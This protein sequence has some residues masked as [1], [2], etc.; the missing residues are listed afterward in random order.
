MIHEIL[1]VGPLQCNCSILGDETSREAIVVD[2]GDDI[3]R[4]LA[5]LARHSLT[6]KQ[7]S[8]AT[9]CNKDVV[10]NVIDGFA[11]EGQV[12]PTKIKK[13]SGKGEREYA[14]WK[15]KPAASPVRSK[16][17]MV[18]RASSMVSTPRSIVMPS[19]PASRTRSNFSDIDASG[20]VKPP[21]AQSA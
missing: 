5:L 3:P 6:V 15:L 11:R 8:E 17:G 13:P 12:V 9:G 1:P 20:E 18:A 10:G 16:C 21:I 19:K 4:I 14:A 2:P 7:I